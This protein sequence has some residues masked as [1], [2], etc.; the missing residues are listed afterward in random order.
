MKNIIIYFS[1]LLLFL[2]VELS[3]VY[4]GFEEGVAAYDR[5]DYETAF[6]EFKPVAEQGDELAQF[7][8]GQLHFMGQGVTQDYAE[9]FKWYRKAAKQGHAEAQYNF[10]LMYYEGE[11]VPKDYAEAYKWFGKAAEHM[12][13]HSTTSD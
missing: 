4:A 3:S 7:Y 2:F 12:Q 5:G 10:G 11:G 13:R 9:A 8:L 6:M 1:V